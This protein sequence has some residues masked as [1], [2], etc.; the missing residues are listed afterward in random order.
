MRQLL[1][2]RGLTPLALAA[3][4]VMVATQLACSDSARGPRFAVTIPA[5]DSG[6]KLD[7]RMLVML[8]TDSTREP[9]FQMA[10]GDAT[11]QLFGMDVNDATA[12]SEV[13]LDD[14]VHG[15]P[16][17]RVA[18]VPAGDYWVQAL[19]HRYETFN[20]ADG[21]TVKLP[22][23]RGEGQQ[24]SR[25][26]GN[27]YST[28]RKIHVDGKAGSTIALEL[29]K[30]I[31][32][33]PD[34]PDTKYVKHVRI[35]SERLSK[36]WG[37]PMHLGAIVL[38]PEGWDTHPNARYPLA[39]YQG[40][41]ERT[42]SGWRDTPPDPSLPPANRDSI[43]V[44]CPNG[45]EGDLC[46]KFGYPRVLQEMGYDFYKQWTGPG[47]PR[48]ILV[49]IQHANPYY[50]DSY[51][52]NSE[53]L[54]PY[55]DAI[56]YELIPEIEK[57]FRG[58]GQGWA[59]GAYGGSTGGWEA[60]AVQVKYPD[61]YNGAYA[62]CPDP[63]DFH[64]FMTVDVYGDSSAYYSTGPWKRTARPG[65]R[66]YLGQTRTTVE[67]ANHLEL[68]LGTRSRSGGQWDIWEAVYSPVGADG[69][70]QRIWDKE[71]GVIDHKVAEYWRENY[72]LVHI[73]RRDWST[74]GP[75]LSGKIHINV[76][77]S[78][79]YYLNNAVYLAEDFLKTAS[80]PAANATVDYG[81]RDEHC[82]SGD[83]SVANA[84]SRLTYH[85]RFI[86][87]LS[88]HWTRTAPAG[89]DVRSWKY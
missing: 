85:T 62:N 16:L 60:L 10:D 43:A 30:V 58:I 80:N 82:W 63:I 49:T 39:V 28:P 54:G 79:N 22:M 14:S 8:S 25:A 89:A 84:F 78:D 55:G 83:H 34:E 9:R 36:F 35:Q 38:L 46:T 77:L 20:R 75:K 53:N 57:R 21:H 18:D 64:R 56:M 31:P 74:L 86:R 42:V 11:Q 4:T 61:E 52:V 59:R 67:Q 72:D 65:Q 26:P 48:V 88:Q 5:N 68:A 45:H 17:R 44:H 66:D 69:Y 13:I 29:D 33:I 71:T 27:L 23:D 41:F 2:A 76:G 3:T 81:A 19:L 15:Y 50:D 1:H 47:F 37:R 32:P 40:H 87:G 24:W 7:G 12:G 6:A 73:M 70:P 51:A